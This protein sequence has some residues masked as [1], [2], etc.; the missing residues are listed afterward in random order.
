M[1]DLRPDIN[2]IILDGLINKAISFSQN[3]DFKQK[4]MITNFMENLKYYIK[5]RKIAVIFKYLLIC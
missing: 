1:L 5:K 4:L 2:F 3:S